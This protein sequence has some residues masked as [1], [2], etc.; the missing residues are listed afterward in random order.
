LGASGLFPGWR[1]PE[2]EQLLDRP[3]QP[4]EAAIVIR[5]G[6]PLEPE[7]VVLAG[8]TPETM[9][10]D[11]VV[12]LKSIYQAIATNARCG[13]LWLQ[14]LASRVPVDEAA[15]AE[16]TRSEMLSLA[17]RTLATDQDAADDIDLWQRVFFLRTMALTQAL[18]SHRLRLLAEI[19]E[20]VTAESGETV[21]NE[22]RLGHHFYL[23]CT[24]KLDVRSRGQQL[25]T[26]GPSDAF[27]AMALMRGERRMTTVTALERTEL[28]TID[29]VDFLDL[30]DA[31][32]ALVRSF[33][34]MLASQIIAA[35][36]PVD[37]AEQST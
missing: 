33:S 28:L 22:G 24:G 32:P 6:R 23:V 5:D 1:L 27:G 18:P 35:S 12:P 34:R 4:G 19:A 30:V 11:I 7:K 36:S 13:G 26:L 2:L 3:A 14:G 16:V 10:S 8:K 20:T 37:T 21:V 31:H 15:A 17:T 29:R 25:A 9:D